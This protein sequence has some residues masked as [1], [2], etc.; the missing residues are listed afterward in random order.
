M[1]QSVLDD[2]KMQMRYG[3]MIVKI[4]LINLFVFLS[5]IVLK[6]FLGGGTIG[7]FDSVLKWFALS[8]DPIDLIRH[9]VSVISHM[10]L[11]VSL[12][13]IFW[14]MLI[15]YWFGRIVG[16]FIGDERILPIYLLGGLCG[17]VAYLLFAAF[18][19]Q[20]S[21]AYGASAAVMAMVVASGFLAPEY[22][23]RLLFI[24][25]VKLKYVAFALVLIDLIMIAEAD[26]TG[27]RIAHLGG[28]VF[29]GF[30]VHLLGL[31]RD[32]TQPMT[33]FG[34]A[35][36][37]KSKKYK[38]TMTVIHNQNQKRELNSEVDIQDRVDEIL[39]KINETGFDSLSEEE[40]EFL[41]QASKK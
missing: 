16:D 25:D 6:A 11:H 22:N 2:I 34:E 33:D 17:A 3:N 10:F 12:G 14:N 9:P 40:K 38:A 5:M 15:L 26:N 32:L 7:S 41:Y 28:A 30:Y 19:G 29:G 37:S 35:V 20:E 23:L 18:T 8:S 24:G 39:D 13:H 27:G 21:I 4:I 1:I 31:G 36:R